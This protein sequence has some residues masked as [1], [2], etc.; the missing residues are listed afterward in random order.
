MNFQQY[1]ESM[2]NAAIQSSSLAPSAR[3]QLLAARQRSELRGSPMG[4]VL[5]QQQRELDHRTQQA[6]IRHVTED[7]ASAIGGAPKT[8]S[9][10]FAKSISH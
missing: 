5:D 6:N 3:Q 1:Y 7:F 9:A 4:R 2:I 10:A 8:D